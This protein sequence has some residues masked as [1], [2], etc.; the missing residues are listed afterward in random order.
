MFEGKPSEG[1]DYKLPDGELPGGVDYGGVT[2]DG[3][4]GAQHLGDKMMGDMSD[5]LMPILHMIACCQMKAID[6]LDNLM[7]RNEGA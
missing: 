3:A 5:I 6:H 1:V 7:L 4:H 2:G